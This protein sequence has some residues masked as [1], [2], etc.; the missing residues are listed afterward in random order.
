MCDD[1]DDDGIIWVCCYCGHPSQ[2]RDIT[3]QNPNPDGASKYPYD[4]F[5]INWGIGHL[6]VMIIFSIN[7]VIEHLAMMILFPTILND[8][9]RLSET[10]VST[11]TIYYDI[12][13]MSSFTSRT[14]ERFKAINFVT[15]SALKGNEHQAPFTPSTSMR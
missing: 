10:S 7:W 5:S 3:P 12:G 14:L 15:T 9:S 8:E 6:A 4:S 13:Y 1:D 11:W 2:S